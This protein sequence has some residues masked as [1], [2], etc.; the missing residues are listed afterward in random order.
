MQKPF[1]VA[2]MELLDDYAD[3]PIDEKL[4]ALSLRIMALQ[5]EAAERD[6]EPDPVE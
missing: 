6:Q 1:E 3:T 2:L 4:S 5:E